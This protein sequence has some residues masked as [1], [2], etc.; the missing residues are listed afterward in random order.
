MILSEKSATFR[1][2]ALKC[3]N[4]AE[5]RWPCGA[6]ELAPDRPWMAR[7]CRLQAA[8]QS[9]TKSR[10]EQR[11]RAHHHQKSGFTIVPLATPRLLKRDEVRATHLDEIAP[12]LGDL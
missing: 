12:V 5:L 2:H 4:T 6:A 1:D 8:A 9:P 10:R 11:P 7:S 3:S